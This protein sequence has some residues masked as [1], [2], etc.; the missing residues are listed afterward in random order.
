MRPIDH[1]FLNK[2]PDKSIAQQSTTEALSK[3]GSEKGLIRFKVMSLCWRAFGYEYGS[4]G[5][6]C[7]TPLSSTS[8]R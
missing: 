8:G 5:M 3:L 2:F 4:R 1:D 6:G 7:A